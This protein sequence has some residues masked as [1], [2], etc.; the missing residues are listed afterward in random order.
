MQSFAALIIAVLVLTNGYGHHVESNT[1]LLKLPLHSFILALRVTVMHDRMSAG[2]SVALNAMLQM[3][4]HTI[5]HIILLLDAIA[6]GYNLRKLGL[7][8][9]QSLKIG[10]YNHILY[11]THS[12]SFSLTQTFS[13]ACMHAII[14]FRMLHL[15]W[16]TYFKIEWENAPNI[17][18]MY[19][20]VV[21]CRFSIDNIETFPTSNGM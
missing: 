11:L 19:H 12:Q 17:V 2:C 9:S 3:W 18:G 14:R 5:F 20:L 15:K 13:F 16:A 21:L 1:L 6:G 8:I 7:A 10:Q 4:K